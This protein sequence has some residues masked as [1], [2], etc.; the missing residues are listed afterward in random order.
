M[1][2]P[3]VVVD[4]PHASLVVPVGVAAEL[5]ITSAALERELLVMT[6]RYTD[7]LFALPPDA[8]TTV[9]FP[10]SRLVVDPE[11]CGD[12]EREPMSRKGMGVMH[13]DFCWTS[14]ASNA[15]AGGARL[16]P[17]AVL[18]AAPRCA[19]G[20][21]HD[22]VRSARLVPRHRRAQL[23][24]PAPPLRGPSTRRPSRHLH[25]DRPRITRHR[26]C[27]TRSSAHSNTRAFA[28]QSTVRLQERWCRWRSMAVTRTCTRS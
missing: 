25:R 13:A 11:R 16:P 18:R 21:G 19:H 20:G 5:L 23:P 22:R 1:C 10:V 12:N 7:E 27:A 8:A 4:V 24:R 17:R 9:T 26:R 6:D 14:A 15:F 2:G 28:S 3:R